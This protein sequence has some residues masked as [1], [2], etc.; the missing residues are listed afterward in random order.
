[1]Q[2]VSFELLCK[3]IPISPRYSGSIMPP[4]GNTPLLASPD[5][6]STFKN[7]TCSYCF[8]VV[9]LSAIWRPVGTFLVS[10]GGI[11]IFSI[12][13][14]SNPTSPSFCSGIIAS[15]CVLIIGINL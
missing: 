5:R 11:S 12:E 14:T 4:T 1:M 2:N 7:C 3:I 15:G 9:M 13:D 10:P 6:P 8:G